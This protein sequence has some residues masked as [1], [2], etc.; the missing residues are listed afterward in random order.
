MQTLRTQQSWLSLSATQ[1]KLKKFEEKKNLMDIN[2]IQRLLRQMNKRQLQIFT[3]MLG[4]MQNFKTRDDAHVLVA[5]RG[6][7]AQFTD[8]TSAEAFDTEWASISSRLEQKRSDIALN[9]TTVK[10]SLS[11]LKRALQEAND[12]QTKMDQAFLLIQFFDN[13]GKI[14]NLTQ[15]LSTTASTGQTNFKTQ[16]RVN[17]TV[18]DVRGKNSFEICFVTQQSQM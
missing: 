10:A 9:Q 6:T 15:I 17:T 16:S 8:Y 11:A 1:A 4:D 12:L 18:A 2:N 13:G 5:A 3:K 14:N 7:T